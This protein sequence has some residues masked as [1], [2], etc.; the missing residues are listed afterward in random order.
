MIKIYS[1]IKYIIT[2]VFCFLILSAISCTKGNI[3]TDSKSSAKSSNELAPSP[4]T[5]VTPLKVDQT[6][7]TL[8]Q[9]DSHR[10]AITGG[11]K[12]YTLDDL[13]TG[14]LNTSNYIFKA[15][16]GINP[17]TELVKVMDA[18]GNSININFKI[19]GFEPELSIK[20]NTLI[21]LQNIYEYGFIV[22]NDGSLFIAGSIS[23]NRGTFEQ[24]THGALLKSTDGG[25]NFDLVYTEPK[26]T[27]LKLLLLPNNNFLIATKEVQASGN[28]SLVLKTS[29]NQGESFTTTSTVN[30]LTFT[31]LFIGKATGALYLTGYKYNDW[32]DRIAYIYRSTDYGV[33]WNQFSTFDY[34]SLTVASEPT[35]VGLLEISASE[36]LITTNVSDYGSVG[37]F[38]DQ[39][40]V[41]RTTNNGNTWTNTDNF[42]LATGKI[43]T[44]H[45]ILKLNDGTILSFGYAQTSTNY[46]T[47]IVRKSTDG[48][49]SWTTA[50]TY[51]YAAGKSSLI[52]DV[53]ANSSG[54]I[55]MRVLGYDSSNAVHFISRSSVDGTT[56][57]QESDVSGASAYFAYPG[58]I[59]EDSLGNMFAIN[60]Y[61][62]SISGYITRT[63]LEVVK[64]T[65]TNVVTITPRYQYKTKSFIPASAIQ[66]SN[67]NILVAGGTFTDNY[68]QNQWTVQISSDNG[69]SWTYSDN[70]IYPGS[71]KTTEIKKIITTSSGALLVLGVANDNSGGTRLIIRK[72][73]P[74]GT[75]AYTWS[76]VNDSRET[77]TSQEMPSDLLQSSSGK[78]LAIGTSNKSG[79]PYW[80]VKRS[81]ADFS[82]WTNVEDLKIANTSS[83]GVSI[84]QDSLGRLYA[85]GY[86]L[87]TPKV[88]YLRASDDDGT[89]WNTI[90]SWPQYSSLILYQLENAKVLNVGIKNGILF[91][92]KSEDQGLTWSIVAQKSYSGTTTLNSIKVDSENI[93]MFGTFS[94]NQQ[95]STT[96]RYNFLSNQFTTLDTRDSSTNHK[97]LTSFNC[98][99]QSWCLL[100][101]KKGT[102]IGET[103]GLIRRMSP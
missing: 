42:S 57:T 22:T 48:G 94:E 25:A 83:Y 58:R 50:N 76:T 39:W 16:V 84:T 13:S 46:Y 73:N 96:L 31:S 74:N 15:P 60:Y 44:G 71:T 40:L 86:T 55:W 30:D 29:T 65:P 53:F 88:Y 45:S 32:H 26:S 52:T 61:N 90:K 2:L 98:Q 37:N 85:L 1:Q 17:I 101:S 93:F 63:E 11:V 10:I 99:G 95:G 79:S 89:T 18:L 100:S 103:I 14:H 28:D 24:Y 62:M 77:A 27:I 80:I 75:N 35:I 7:V 33:T 78:V 41:H 51:N 54:K 6:M 91:I 64:K 34:T 87:T 49:T 92:E 67:S 68:M 4:N 97:G 102:L 36:L 82:T 9:G 56:W 69:A 66:D 72:G 5:L 70:Y 19:R 47:I 38:A 23:L 20:S 3:E 12:P 8:F 59:A 43:A 81:S 21:N